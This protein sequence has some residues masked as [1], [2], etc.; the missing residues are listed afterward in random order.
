MLSMYCAAP[1]P[2][3]EF[4]DGTA[5]PRW[6]TGTHNRLP[7][8]N[9]PGGAESA[10]LRAW[11][12]RWDPAAWEESIVVDMSSD[13]RPWHTPLPAIVTTLP[14]FVANALVGD[15]IIRSLQCPITMEPIAEITSG[16]SVTPCYHIFDYD[17]LA[18]WVATGNNTCPLC[19]A[20]L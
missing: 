18:A 4:Q 1:I 5:S 13:T 16:V 3:L 10:F 7:L 12:R 15:A 14:G 19:K 6:P 20:P 17:A 8:T 9:I 2:V 11:Q